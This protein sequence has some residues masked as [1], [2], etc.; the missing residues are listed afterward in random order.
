MKNTPMRLASC[1]LTALVLCACN[2]DDNDDGDA[3]NTA[4]SANLLPAPIP[5]ARG[6]NAP[7][8]L[9]QR[10][11]RAGRPAITAALVSAFEA[12]ADTKSRDVAAYNTSGLSNPAFLAT[13]QTSL[14][15]LDGLDGNCGN[16]LLADPMG[17]RYVPLAQVLL[18]DQLYLNSNRRGSVYLGVEAEAVQLV[19]DG[20]GA[21]GGRE[22][23]D[24]VI[25][26]S[27]SVLAAGAFSGIDDGVP[28]DDQTHNPDVFPFLAAPR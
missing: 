23:G 25:A 2:G 9:G 22:P 15:I 18:D 11:D 7:P 26:R 21:G 1:L 20:G 27:Y 13:I 3:V 28:S 17:Q 10:I 4:G 16:Q 8:V 14:G 24:D 6:A 5:G 12:D 19:G